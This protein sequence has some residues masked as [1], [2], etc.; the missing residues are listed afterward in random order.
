MKKKK[1]F[2]WCVCWGGS[3]FDY[4][5]LMPL[6]LVLV[7]GSLKILRTGWAR[8]RHCSLTSF[9]RSLLNTEDDPDSG[10]C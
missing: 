4:C 8:G 3:L 6:F 2:F 9:N 7:H 5:N 1:N 10:L